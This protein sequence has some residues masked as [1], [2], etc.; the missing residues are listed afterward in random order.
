MTE[1]IIYHCVHELYVAGMWCPRTER[2]ITGEKV[3]GVPPLE[4]SYHEAPTLIRRLTDRGMTTSWHYQ[5]GITSI[6]TS[7]LSSLRLRTTFLKFGH[8]PC[9]PFCWMTDQVPQQVVSVHSSSR[10]KEHDSPAGAPQVS[11][12]KHPFDDD[13]VQLLE[14]VTEISEVLGDSMPK[15]H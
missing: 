7:P 5:Q 10:V 15:W 8:K 6:R 2:D 11:G 14:R 3:R 12:E 4:Q 9:E 13:I 1:S